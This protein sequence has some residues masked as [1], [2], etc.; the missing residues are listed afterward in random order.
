VEPVSRRSF[1]SGV[2]LLPLAALVPRRVWLFSY[3]AHA[4]LR[5]LSSREASVVEAAAARLIPGPSDDPAEMGHPG[6]REAKVVRYIDTLL[7]ALGPARA[8]VFAGGPFSRRHGGAD[9][10]RDFVALDP[11]EKAAWTARLS[12]L[13]EKYRSG[14]QVLDARA[15]GDFVKATP[16][17]QDAILAQDPDGFMTMLMQHAIEGMYS[18]PEYGGNARLVGWR[19]I[20]FPGDTQ[21]RGYRDREVSRSDG[22]DPYEPDAVVDAAIKLITSTAPPGS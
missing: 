3:S 15:G 19:E 6:A 16:A 2:S 9:S 18:A 20:K 17:D 21:P 22:P 10:F 12:E 8:R 5:A 7:G 1:L 4:P 13:T 11:V 14:V